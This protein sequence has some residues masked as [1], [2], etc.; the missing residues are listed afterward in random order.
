M[1]RNLVTLLSNS[2]F[3]NYLEV[4]LSF[5]LAPGYPL[6]PAPLTDQEAVLQTEE[7][8]R[9]LEAT[10]ERALQVFLD[11]NM[12]TPLGTLSNVKPCK[13]DFSLTCM[14]QSHHVKMVQDL[15]YR[16]EHNWQLSQCLVEPSS[17]VG[18]QKKW[19]SEDLA[20]P[21]NTQI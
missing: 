14:P 20:T 1:I 9:L 21:R 18:V 16:I 7:D 11:D 8:L 3:I 10:D 17:L 5:C 12:L 4:G 2:P 15:K 13:L 6:G 19:P